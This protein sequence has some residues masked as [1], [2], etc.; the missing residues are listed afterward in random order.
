[1][2]RPHDHSGFHGIDGFF[3]YRVPVVLIIRY[4][5]NEFADG[6]PESLLYLQVDNIF[7]ETGALG[8]GISSG[9]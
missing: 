2:Y 8:F 9:I 6:E 1:M 3:L 4:F 7:P 5:H